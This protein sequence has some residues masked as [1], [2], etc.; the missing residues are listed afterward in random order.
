MNGRP[1]NSFQILAALL[2]ECRLAPR[3]SGAACR[4]IRLKA[5]LTCKVT[6]FTTWPPEDSLT[7][8]GHIV[9][10]LA[11]DGPVLRA[12]E[13]AVDGTNAVD[14][15]LEVRLVALERLQPGIDVLFVTENAKNLENLSALK[16][17]SVLTIGESEEFLE[18]GRI[19]RFRIVDER[20]TFEINISAAEDAGLTLSSRLLHLARIVQ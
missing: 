20:I 7:E 2:S 19:V 13:T 16:G 6:L 11:G 18:A 12:I 17:K 4:R 10:G 15:T 3:G 14:R 9:V 8:D 5:A 1:F